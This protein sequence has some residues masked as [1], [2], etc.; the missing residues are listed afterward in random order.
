MYPGWWDISLCL[1]L[2]LEYIKKKS[3]ETINELTD[4]IYQLACLEQIGDGSDAAIEFE[5]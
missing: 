1:S 5:V 3:D 2:Q 4:C